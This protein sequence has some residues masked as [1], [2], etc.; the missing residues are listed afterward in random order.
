MLE[1]HIREI[2]PGSEETPADPLISNI[3][4]EGLR[5]QYSVTHNTRKLPRQ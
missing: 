2:V 3:I 1:A 4:K 5:S